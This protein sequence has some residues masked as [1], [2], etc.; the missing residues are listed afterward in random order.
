MS[1]VLVSRTQSVLSSQSM[2]TN[3]LNET[4]IAGTNRPALPGNIGHQMGG[5]FASDP[6]QHDDSF[7]VQ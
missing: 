3:Q 2:Q 5:T 7:S 6:F 4:F 1:L